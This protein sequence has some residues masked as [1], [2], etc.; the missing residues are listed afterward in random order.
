MK[1]LLLLSFLGITML[2]HSQTNYLPNV[3]IVKAKESSRGYFHKNETSNLK[4]ES[5]YK[6]YGVTSVS[7]TYPNSTKPRTETNELGIKYADISLIYTLEYKA[8]V[9]P[10]S[11][12]HKFM[13]T[14]VFQY[15]EPSFTFQP[16][17]TPNDPEID[18]LYFLDLLNLYT[19]W[20]TEK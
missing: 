17:Y 7:R 1:K 6:N 13:N 14:G 5:L 12:I 20:D 4:L 8:D 2:S 18:S 19:A 9:D 15:V 3:L 16:L 10:K 11:L